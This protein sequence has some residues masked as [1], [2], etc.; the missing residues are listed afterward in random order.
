MTASAVAVGS[1]ATLIF[2]GAEAAVHPM[3]LDVSSSGRL[4]HV[5][6]VPP[7][8]AAAST[9]GFA[10]ASEALGLESWRLPAGRHW[11]SAC[12][13]DRYLYIAA[14]GGDVW[15]FDPPWS[16]RYDLDPKGANHHEEVFTV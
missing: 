2:S 16:R 4:L 11:T 14:D 9:K 12:A 1:N 10:T 8:S 13:T 5:W 7:G 15:R 3:L 6:K